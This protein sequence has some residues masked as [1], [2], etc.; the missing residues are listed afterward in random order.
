VEAVQDH[1]RQDNLEDQV[2]A[3][4]ELLEITQDK[5]LVELEIHHLYH[6]HRVI[7]EDQ[8]IDQNL[9]K[10]T[11]LLAEEAVEPEPEEGDL[12][13]TRINLEEAVKEERLLLQVHQLIMLE[14]E[15]ADQIHHKAEAKVV[16]ED[17]VAEELQA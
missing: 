14:E 13:E 5:L 8:E 10:V 7:M 3:D 1:Q 16:V 15:L 12:E 4:Q 2:A 17:L 11:Y 9:T 6:L